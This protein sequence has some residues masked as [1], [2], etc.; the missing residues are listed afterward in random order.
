MLKSGC[1]R[2]DQSGVVVGV[3]D[4]DGLAGPVA[5]GRAERD[6]IRLICLGDFRR[7]V[8][9]D[10]RASPAGRCHFVRARCSVR[11]ARHD[12]EK[13]VLDHTVARAVLG[14]PVRLAPES[15][16]RLQAFQNKTNRPPAPRGAQG[17]DRPSQCIRM[18]LSRKVAEPRSMRAEQSPARRPS[19]SSCRRLAQAARLVLSLK[20]RRRDC[21][22]RQA[23]QHT[24]GLRR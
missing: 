5:H 9:R 20:K 19:P 16:P 21:R 8:S 4:R 7:C 11:R 24:A 6:G 12:R 1:R 13:G 10:R 17:C 2:V 18:P 3:D 15:E 14:R 22:G 23:N